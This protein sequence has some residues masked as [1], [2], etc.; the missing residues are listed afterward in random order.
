MCYDIEMFILVMLHGGLATIDTYL[1][2]KKDLFC[3]M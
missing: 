3:V 1:L 2:V